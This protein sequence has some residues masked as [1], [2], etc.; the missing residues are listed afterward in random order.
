MQVYTEEKKNCL[1]FNPI[2]DIDV[3]FQHKSASELCRFR[4][5]GLSEI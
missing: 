1:R 3:C 5:F 2:R 4:Q